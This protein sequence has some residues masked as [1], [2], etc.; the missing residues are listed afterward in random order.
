MTDRR[1]GDSAELISVSKLAK[2]TIGWECE[3][4]DIETILESMWNVYKLEKLLH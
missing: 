1:P 3:H 2:N 4:S